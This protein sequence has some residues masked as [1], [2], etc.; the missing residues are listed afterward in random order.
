MTGHNRPY[1]FPKAVRISEQ[2]TIRRLFSSKDKIKT[3]T[4]TLCSLG[5]TRPYARLGIVVLKKKIGG[6]WTA[7]LLRGWFGRYF[8][9]TASKFRPA[10]I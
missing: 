6:R 9:A 3:E 7:T 4:F 10:T 1:R 2:N 5:G 8:A